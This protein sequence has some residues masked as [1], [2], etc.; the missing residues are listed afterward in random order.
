MKAQSASANI[1][2]KDRLPEVAQALLDPSAYPDKPDRVELVQTQMS[3]V[4]LA[5]LYAY[6]VKKAVNLGYLDYTS[7]AK[8][9]FYCEQEVQ[10]NSRLCPEFYL[11]VVPIIRSGRSISVSP[12]LSPLPQRGEEMEVRGPSDHPLPQRGEEMEV[13]GASDHPLLQRKE[14]M[15]V[16]GPSDHPLPFFNSSSS[17]GR[18]MELRSASPAK[19]KTV[20]RDTR[21][22][23]D[24]HSDNKED[25]GEVIEYAVKMHRVPHDRMLNVLLEEG[26]VS[27]EMLQKLAGKIAVFH[28]NAETNET[29]RSYGRTE[30][31]QL[32]VEENFAQTRKY[33]GIALTRTQFRNIKD[34][35]R[36][37]L[38]EKAKLFEQRV[39]DGRIRDCHGDLYA[40]HICFCDGICV[41]DCI[42]FNDRFRYID[43]ASEVAFLAMDLDHFGRADLSRSFV[44]A[45]IQASQD[46]GVEALL[47]FY[48]AYR[49]YVRG[50]VQCFSYDDPYLSAGE[51]DRALET[52]RDYFDLAA[53]YAR[54]RPLLL[55]TVG[56]VG[57]GKTT[58]AG[59]LAR[60]LGLTVISS[61]V[62]RKTMAGIPLTEHRFGEMHSGIYSPAFSWRTYQRMYAQAK[63]I[64]KSGDPVILDATFV[65]ADG[66]L[67]A[68]KLAE[69][70]GAD[71]AVVECRLNEEETRRRLEQRLREPSV[72]DARWEV[73]EYQKKEFEP[74]TEVPREKHFVVDTGKPLREQITRL[75]E[76]LLE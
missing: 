26:R 63:K 76:K 15:E 54:P 16:R 28:F 40:Q 3:F 21:H 57:S 59:A 7:L 11:G 48:K 37:F 35:T 22:P 13:R 62:V 31:I 45:Y 71:F 61:D 17:R 2:G 43:T 32:N 1:D 67:K 39:I 10:L 46:T 70:A 6:K 53:S 9:R 12:H 38:Q 14:E 4:F 73:Y 52:A 51:R 50:K 27:A 75:I 8:R 29:I 42:E 68:Q 55:I 20:E 23:G 66:R 69:E 56:L 5:G 34:Y 72:S 41:F 47:K 36:R 25:R 64:L 60:R 49:A 18:P 30:A 19:E 33:A 65:R 44:Y 74:V 58:L 24:G